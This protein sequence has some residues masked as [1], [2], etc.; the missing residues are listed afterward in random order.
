MQKS[1]SNIC[2]VSNRALEHPINE[3]E[4][5]CKLIPVCLF[6]SFHFLPVFLKTMQYKHSYK[7]TAEIIYM[8]P[9]FCNLSLEEYNRIADMDRMRKALV[10]FMVCLEI[11]LLLQVK[12]I[13]KQ[14]PRTPIVA[15][16]YPDSYL[17]FSPRN[18][19]GY[20]VD[21]FFPDPT[22]R[23]RQTIGK[24]KYPTLGHQTSM[25]E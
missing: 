2:H 11:Y 14:V 4:K 15:C 23:L 25:Y 22:F 5:F 16:I 1:Q 21:C 19:A 10:C 7:S 9:L 6:W 18:T 17:S 24:L 13:N 8:N 20:R 3:N 12:I